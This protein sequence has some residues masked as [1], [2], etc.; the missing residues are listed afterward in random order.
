MCLLFVT[1]KGVSANHVLRKLRQGVRMEQPSA[2]PGN[3]FALMKSCWSAEARDRPKFKSLE[4]E[5]LYKTLRLL[6]I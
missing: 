3:V 1:I 2:C 6:L 5:L 4:G